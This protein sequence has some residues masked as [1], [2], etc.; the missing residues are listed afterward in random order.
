MN[1]SLI[2]SDLM[3]SLTYVLAQTCSIQNYS[4]NDPDSV[5]ETEDKTWADVTTGISCKISRLSH[6]KNEIR[7]PDKT[8]VLHPYAIVL[9][10]VYSVTEDNRISSGGNY[11]DILSVDFDSHNTFTSLVCERVVW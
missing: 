3:A 5:G 7:R 2:H 8:I 10:G 4:L 1:K 6:G 11:Y 9:D